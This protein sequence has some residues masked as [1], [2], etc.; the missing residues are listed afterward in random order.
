[1]AWRCFGRLD[2]Y[3]GELDNEIGLLRR[4]SMLLRL[5]PL[6][7]IE[8]LARGLEPVHVSAGQTVFSRFGRLLLCGRGRV[9]K[10]SAT[11]T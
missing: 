10:W 6:P 3:S 5:L 2:G 1:V 11:A 8:H 4:V 9:R 7:A